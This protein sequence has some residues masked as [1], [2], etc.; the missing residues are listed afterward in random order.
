MEPFC[1]VKPLDKREREFACASDGFGN[2]LSYPFF[3]DGPKDALGHRVVVAIRSAAHAA[4]APGGLHK[5]AAIFRRV[6]IGCAAQFAEESTPPL[7]W[8]ELQDLVTKD[9]QATLSYPLYGRIFRSLAARFPVTW[10]IQEAGKPGFVALLEKAYFPSEFVL[11]H[12][13]AR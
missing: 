8:G 4:Q 7:T 11:E 5:V 6:G 9:S 1:I 10:L 3:L 12:P 2:R 13:I